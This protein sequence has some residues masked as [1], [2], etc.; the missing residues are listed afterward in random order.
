MPGFGEGPV[1]FVS[2]RF[3]C[4]FAVGHNNLAYSGTWRVWTAKNQPDLY[5]AVEK[6][7]GDLK[8]TV[9]CPRP[10]H[11]TWRRHLHIP[12]EAS[13]AVAVAVKKD[14]GPHQFH[15]TGCAI[16]PDCTLEFRVIFA[17][18]SLEKNGTTARA[19]TALLR[20]PTEQE[21]VAVAVLLGPATPTHGYPREAHAPTHLL[22]EG[23]LSDGRRVWVVYCTKSVETNSEP[24]PK[25]QSVI[26]AKHYVDPTVDFSN[27]SM[28]GA[29]FGW[30]DDG[31][32]T[33]WDVSAK[34]TAG[35]GGGG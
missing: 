15:W 23:R 2:N 8:A 10:P 33:F 12:I 29:L 17:G 7:S 6:I 26:P 14:S 34:Y 5:L 1:G 24:Q 28:R 21:F 22:S 30:Q 3:V 4:R 31:S 13:G 18:K 11:T 9:H 35:I 20:I 19:D 25:Q 32:L 16:G 27:V